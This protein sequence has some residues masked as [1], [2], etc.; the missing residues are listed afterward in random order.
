MIN[1]YSDENVRRWAYSDEEVLDDDSQDED[2]ILGSLPLSLLLPLIDD[3]GCP[4]ADLLLACLDYHHM[5]VVLRGDERDLVEVLGAAEKAQHCTRPEVKA[6]GELLRRRLAYRVGVGPVDH[7]I[8][9]RMGY[10]L[11]KGFFGKVGEIAIS[12]ETPDEITV[13]CSEPP[14]HE[15]R[16]WITISKQ[17]GQFKWSWKM[18]AT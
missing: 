15:Y 3:P 10:D 4:K 2:L 8:A 1:P 13:Q 11:F 6:W 16:E 9:L 12:D 14:E 18:Q 7:E 17:T 5:H